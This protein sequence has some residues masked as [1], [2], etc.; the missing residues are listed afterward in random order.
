MTS[1]PGMGFAIGMARQQKN[2]EMNKPN[3]R[4]AITGVAMDKVIP[5]KCG[6]RWLQACFAL[7]LLVGLATLAWYM[8]PQGLLVSATEL[9][10]ASVEQGIYLDD[11]MLRATAEPLNSVVL[12]TV[13]SGRVEEVFA[14]DGSMVKQGQLLFR[15]SNPQR[16]LELLARQAEHTQQISNL[17]NLRVNFQLGNTDHQRRLSALEFELAQT[18]KQHARNEKLAEQSFISLVALEES[19]DKLARAQFAVDEEKTSRDAELKVKHDAQLQME[20]GIRGLQSGLQLVNATVAALAVRAPVAGRLTDFHLQVGETM[21]AGKR[22]GRIDDPRLVKLGAQIDE[23]YLNRIASGRSGVAHLGDKTLT[24]VVGKVF[25]QIKDGRFK[26]E[27]EFAQGQDYAISPGQSLEANITLGEPGQ[28]ML[29]P[30]TSFITDTGGNWVFVLKPDG[31]QALRR[32]IK[33][34]RRN[35]RQIEVLSGLAKGDKVIVSGYAN[36]L[37]AKRLQINN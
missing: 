15:L 34:G 16:N 20:N 4:P 10:I 9:R 7:L 31:T 12:D 32:E 18:K 1:L 21:I 28:A 5:R 24:I 14:Q 27:L 11:L 23:Y 35:N 3:V 2:P 36:F 30:N 37:N 6:Q 8:L 13:E 19:A 29:L 22:I 17:A 26:V 33:I 25:P